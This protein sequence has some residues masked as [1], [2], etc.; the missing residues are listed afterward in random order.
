MRQPAIALTA[1]V[2]PEERNKALAAGFQ[3]HIAKP[4]DPAELTSAIVKLVRQ[5]RIQLPA[6]AAMVQALE[7]T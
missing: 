2:P 1:C 6:P 3:M 7:T 4:L 5:S